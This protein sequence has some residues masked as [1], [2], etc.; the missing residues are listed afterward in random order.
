MQLMIEADH[1]EGKLVSLFQ[2]LPADKQHDLLLI[3]E[4]YHDRHGIDG[5]AQS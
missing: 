4:A 5:T 2:K 3:A 1:R